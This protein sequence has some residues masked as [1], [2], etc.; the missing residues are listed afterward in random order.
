[1]FIKE[2]DDAM[3]EIKS[4]LDLVM[5]RTQNLSLSAEEKASLRRK[6]LEGRIKGWVQKNLD[7]L[8]DLKRLKAEM[9]AIPEQDR[10][11]GRMLLKNLALQHLDPE[12]NNE[13]IL[14]ILEGMLGESRQSYLAAVTTFREMAAA[15]RS[16]VLAS[17]RAG[18]ADRQVSGSAVVPNLSKD[19]TWNLYYQKALAEF[20]KGIA[21]IPPG[22]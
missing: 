8:M 22:N 18:L 9:A 16:R 21:L 11:E 17:L 1:M 20:R 12:A 19:E 4:T 2:M 7:G 10:K 6:E 15:E 5:E 3:A 13:R 14:G